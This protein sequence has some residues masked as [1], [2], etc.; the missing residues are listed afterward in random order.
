[1]TSPSCKWCNGTGSIAVEPNSS[2]RYRC[3]D[4]HGTG[5][6]EIVDEPDEYPKD[7]ESDE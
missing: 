4:C 5:R 2:Q 1:M 6:Q 7:E 3:P